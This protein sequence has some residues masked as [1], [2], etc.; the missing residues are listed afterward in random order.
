MLLS[1][2]LVC[3]CLKVYEKRKIDML[4]PYVNNRLYKGFS[5]VNLKNKLWRNEDK[6][7]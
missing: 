7:K 6:L 4:S 1:K 3:S 2:R 5:F